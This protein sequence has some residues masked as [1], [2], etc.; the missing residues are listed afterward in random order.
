MIFVQSSRNPGC[1]KFHIFDLSKAVYFNQVRYSRID[2][3]KSL[4]ESNFVF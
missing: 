3:I 1:V 2:V 4:G